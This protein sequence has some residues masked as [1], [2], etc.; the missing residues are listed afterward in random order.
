MDECVIETFEQETTKRERE[1]ERV[2]QNGKPPT[3]W[4]EGREKYSQAGAYT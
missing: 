4:L 1:K 3:A 2:R